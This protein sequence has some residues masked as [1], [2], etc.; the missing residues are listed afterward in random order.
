MENSNNSHSE[1]DMYFATLG[2]FWPLFII[3]LIFRRKSDYCRFHAYQSM[4][5]FSLLI[6]AMVYSSFS[7]SPYSMP[8]ALLMISFLLAVISVLLTLSLRSWKLPIVGS[9][10]IDR[11][12]LTETP[13]LPKP[14]TTLKNSSPNSVKRSYS[15]YFT[16][17][18]WVSLVISVYSD[19]TTITNIVNSSSLK[20]TLYYVVLVLQIISTVGF[21]VLGLMTVRA[22]TKQK[23]NA[24]SLARMYLVV[25]F[26][27][28]FLS[29]IFSILSDT[30][31]TDNTSYFESDRMIV[32]S[33][34]FT[35]GWLIYLTYSEEIL[36]TF[37]K[38][39]RQLRKLDLV[40]FIVLIAI[41]ITFN[42]VG[43]RNDYKEGRIMENITNK[44]SSSSTWK[45]VRMPTKNVSISF[46]RQPKHE[47]LADESIEGTN[48]TIKED[49][50]QSSAS[51]GNTYIAVVYRYSSGNIK[52]SDRSE[53][54]HEILMGIVESSPGNELVSSSYG[55]KDSVSTTDFVITNGGEKVTLKGRLLLNGMDM[56]KM[57]LVNQNGQSSEENYNKFINS[58]KVLPL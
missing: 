26:A 30:S 57:I 47:V 11:M 2:Y 34:I 25:I 13:S 18:I 35:I 37:P 40:L 55:A 27:T 28:N 42:V 15:S 29:V 8:V 23:P 7:S 41:P 50:Y 22:F 9:F 49:A 20:T 54:L 10:I 39:K 46:P 14:E 4:F 3:P 44:F 16:Y 19:I 31:L 32:K 53:F 51:D 5:I 33:F 36:S 43:L 38:D 12:G 24:I 1:H 56:Y 48:I 21:I 52:E 58:F 45:E 6:L 17:C